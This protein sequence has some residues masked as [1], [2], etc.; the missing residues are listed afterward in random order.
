MNA[1]PCPCGTGQAYRDCCA[2]LHA[3]GEAATAEALMRSRFSAFAR[4]DAAYLIRTSHPLA[5]ARMRAG[6]FRTSFALVW[7]RLEVLAVARGGRED[8]DGVVR[9]RAHYRE[10]ERAGVLDECSRFSRDGAAWVYR[11]G[12]GVLPEA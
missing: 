3:G 12:R 7:T 8:A 5:R 9:F 2:P 1:Q 11:D 6:D 10:G 4:R